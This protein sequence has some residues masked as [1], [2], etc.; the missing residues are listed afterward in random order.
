MAKYSEEFN[1]KLVTEYLHG[2]IGTKLQ[3]KVYFVD[4][5]CIRVVWLIS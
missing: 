4:K 1:M 3:Y 2:N 5:E